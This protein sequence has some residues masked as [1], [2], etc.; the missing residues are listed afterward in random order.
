MDAGDVDTTSGMAADGEIVWFWRSD[1]G[2]KI[3]R[4]R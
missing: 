3:V 2:V 4:R 1:A